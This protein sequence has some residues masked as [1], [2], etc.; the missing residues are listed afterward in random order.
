MLSLNLSTFSSNSNSMRCTNSGQAE[1]GS[2]NVP[3]ASIGPES[4]ILNGKLGSAL[5]FECTKISFLSFFTLD[6]TGQ[7]LV[8]NGSLLAGA[9]MPSAVKNEG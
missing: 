5:F 1:L 6:T 8:L 9:G 2:H 7:I 4:L 3:S